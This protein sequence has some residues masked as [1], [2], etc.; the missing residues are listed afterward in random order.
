MQIL[1]SKANVK[2]YQETKEKVIFCFG[3]YRGW[4]DNQID[5]V[6]YSIWPLK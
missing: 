6:E 2:T 4:I 5:C 1:I 3:L